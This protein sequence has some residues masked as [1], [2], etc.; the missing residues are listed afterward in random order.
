[1]RMA[2]TR[3]VYDG[4]D[5]AADLRQIAKCYKC[6]CRSCDR[7]PA[8]D[9]HGHI[10]T[11]GEY[12]KMTVVRLSQ[13][14]LCAAVTANRALSEIDSMRRQLAEARAEVERLQSVMSS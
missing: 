7:D 9:L 14:R 5:I 11:D 3:H 10:C 1:M 6:G 8:G 2:E 4:K 12:C 13:Y